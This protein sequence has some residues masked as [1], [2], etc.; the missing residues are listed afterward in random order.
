[1]LSAETL[2]T[3]KRIDE[4]Q[5]STD[6]N[7]RSTITTLSHVVGEVVEAGNNKTYY[8][9]EDD[10]GNTYKFLKEDTTVV[11]P[12]RG[13]MLEYFGEKYLGQEGFSFDVMFASQISSNLDIAS[14]PEA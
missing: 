10:K 9:Q 14:T 12:S 3:T 7:G 6:E 1:M 5:I 8:V 4:Y 2:N 11:H 13:T